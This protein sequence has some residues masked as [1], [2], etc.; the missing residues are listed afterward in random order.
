MESIMFHLP[1]V[2]SSIASCIAFQSYGWLVFDM[3][4]IPTKTCKQALNFTMAPLGIGF[5]SKHKVF[6]GVEQIG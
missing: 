6:E 5:P 3:H 2:T 1:N 4:H